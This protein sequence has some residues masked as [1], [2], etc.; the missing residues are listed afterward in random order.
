MKVKE[1]IILLEKI[2]NKEDTVEVSIHQSNK[3]YP[4]AYCQIQKQPHRLQNCQSGLDG[5][6]HR[7]EVWL[8]DNMYTGVRKN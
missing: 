7:I 8:P 6:L 1:L 5:K 3:V 4:I 2:E